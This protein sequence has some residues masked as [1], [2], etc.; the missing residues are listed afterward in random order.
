MLELQDDGQPRL[1]PEEAFVSLPD[2]LKAGDRIELISMPEDPDPIE[3][4]TQGTITWV[5]PP[6]WGE[7]QYAVKWDNGRNLGL[8]PVDSVKV[9]R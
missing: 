9:L 6:V 1:R 2:E 8:A 4:G 5:G 7:P 3:P